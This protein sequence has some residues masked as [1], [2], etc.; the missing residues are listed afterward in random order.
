[1]VPGKGQAFTFFGDQI[2]YLTP[3]E[4]MYPGGRHGQMNSQGGLPLFDYYTVPPDVVESDYGASLQLYTSGDQK[5]GRVEHVPRIGMLP[6][7]VTYP[8]LAVWTALMYVH[9]NGPIALGVSG[10]DA[11]IL[12]DGQD[13]AASPSRPLQPGWHQITV[14]AT[15]NAPSEVKL[16]FT[17]SG[18]NPAEVPREQLWAVSPGSGLLGAVQPADPS[19][20]SKGP[21]VRTDQFIGFT[22]L[23]TGDAFGPQVMASV[24][25]RAR[26]IGQLHVT[27]QGT[28]LLEVKSNGNSILLIDGKKVVATCARTDPAS[29]TAPVGLNSG[30]HSIQLDYVGA[31]ASNTLELYWTTPDAGRSLIPPAAL[32][33]A[34]DTAP[35]PTQPP[36]PPDAVDCQA[37]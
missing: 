25:L 5:P 6:T 15:L 12:L 10:V 29:A 16:M 37:P 19:Q 17:G 32:R 14:E 7:D 28:Y 30:W 1:L 35:G 23:A 36:T 8:V 34:P 27:I 31:E 9:D 26:W 3:V 21:L 33:F 4:L 18:A 22:G 2:Q 11:S 24:P 13:Y 20:P